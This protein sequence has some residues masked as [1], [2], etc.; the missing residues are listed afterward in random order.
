M[1]ISISYHRFSYYR[2]R[3]CN[4]NNNNN[5]V[6]C[7]FSIFLLAFLWFS[8]GFFPEISPLVSPD[9]FFGRQVP[10][11]TDSTP[12]ISKSLS[13]NSADLLEISQIF[14]E[15]SRKFNKILLGINRIVLGKIMKH[16]KESTRS[17][18]IWM[19]IHEHLFE[20]QWQ[21]L[22]LN[23]ISQNNITIQHI[24]SWK[25]VKAMTIYQE[26][27]ICFNRIWRQISMIQ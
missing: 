18:T 23:R 19:K 10:K 3:G 21:L 1:S 24:C 5:N 26:R 4:N 16:Y 7:G 11:S 13:E 22:T 8:I 14:L 27:V 20:C 25:P 15:M 17:L 6:F 9:C 12:E 2:G